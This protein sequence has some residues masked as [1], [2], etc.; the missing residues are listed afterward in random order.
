MEVINGVLNI[1]FNE[2]TGVALGNF[3]GV[4]LGH[5]AL[6]KTLKDISAK[7]G[8]KSI[9]FTFDDH[10]LKILEPSKAPLLL[11]DNNK[12]IELIKNLNVDYLILE[13]FNKQFSMLNY[14]DFI[15]DILIDKLNAGFVVVGQDFRFGHNGEGN[16]DI[17]KQF[18]AKYNYEV[19]V[20]QPVIVDG[21][22]V[23]SSFIRGLIK[24]GRVD[25]VPRY[26]GRYHTVEGFVIKG[27]NYGAKIVGFPTANVDVDKELCLPPNGVYITKTVI[28]G[29]HY[30]SLTNI[31]YSPTF[32]NKTFSI[33][34][35][36]L[37][38]FDKNLYGKLVEIEF[39][40]HIRGESK[41]TDVASLRE[42]I[43]N[44]INLAL[45]YFHV[46]DT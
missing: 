12:K 15:E 46:Q 34:T 7:Y 43:K 28:D 25:L 19:E 27:K 44:D 9:V 20:V 41:F 29:I 8:C 26:L 18:S 17:L 2:K 1:K 31:G 38:G 36:I 32:G 6:I 24:D 10:T 4:H 37:D 33:E 21:I 5:V 14:I 3:D 11:T 42:K 40:K 39:L 45:D 30:H 35:Y 13:K 16:I 22:K 23:S